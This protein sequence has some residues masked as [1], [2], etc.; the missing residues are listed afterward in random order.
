MSVLFFLYTRISSE[1][2]RESCACPLIG[3]YIYSWHARQKPAAASSRQ[4]ELGDAASHALR[5]Q[6]A[7]TS[8]TISALS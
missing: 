7:P 8:V 2:E 1:L 5:A 3:A 4:V 6:A